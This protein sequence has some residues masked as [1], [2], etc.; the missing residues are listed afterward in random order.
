MQYYIYHKI[1]TWRIGTR[2]VCIT[3]VYPITPIS[4]SHMPSETRP[5]GPPAF[6]ATSHRRTPPWPRAQTPHPPAPSATNRASIH[7]P[8]GNTLRVSL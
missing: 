1:K 5:C 2:Q 3:D 6:H 8:K 4:P 7:K